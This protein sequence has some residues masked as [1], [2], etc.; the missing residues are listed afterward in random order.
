MAGNDFDPGELSLFDPRFISDPHPVYRKVRAQCPVAVDPFAG[1]PMLTRHEDIADALRTPGVYSSGMDATALGN[2]R[3]LIPL[4]VDPPLHTEYRKLLDPRFSR[5][6]VRELEGDVRQLAGRLVNDFVENGRCEFNSE[7]AIPFPCSV[8]LGLMGLPLEDLDTFLA[9]KNGIIRPPATDQ[10]DAEAARE[11]AAR[12]IDDYFTRALARKKKNPGEDLMSWFLGAEIEGR[13]LT[14][15]EVLGICF[16]FLLGGLDTVTATLGCSVEWL[17]RNP[18]DR[19]RLVADPSLLPGAVDELLRFHTPVVGVARVLRRGVTLG[20]H[21]YEAGQPITLLL[22]SAN[23]DSDAFK[24]GDS[25]KFD[26]EPNPHLAFGAGPHRCLG[27]HLARMELKIALEELHK[28]I[29]SYAIADGEKVRF[30]LA[31]REVECLP[32]VFPPGIR[33]QADAS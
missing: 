24:E 23:T 25:V 1:N 18:V 21:E 2:Q 20:G 17:A 5:A 9:L 13:K 11:R 29:P 4:Q 15:D 16:L 30:G 3:P 14:H 22:G 8:F 26:R 28:R 7:F 27:S 31:I 12:K 6:R 33:T 32:L 10:Q 19:A